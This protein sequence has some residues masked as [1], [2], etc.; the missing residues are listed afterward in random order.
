MGGERGSGAANGLRCNIYTRN[1]VAHC[2]V[3]CGVFAWGT[4]YMTRSWI[5]G[6]H[7]PC[8]TCFGL[9][10]L[11]ALNRSNASDADQRMAWDL[12]PPRKRQSLGP[13]HTGHG[14]SCNTHT[15]TNYGTQRGQ[16]ECSHSLQ[17]TPKDLHANLCA[18]VLMPPV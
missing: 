15:H 17:V 1:I 8:K 11:R 14:V 4:R 12:P 2:R 18:N 13:V 5:M 6:P 16:W 10:L 7:L 3:E 9:C